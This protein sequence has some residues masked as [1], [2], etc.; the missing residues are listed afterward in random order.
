MRTD[1]LTSIPLFRDLP[2]DEFKRLAATLKVLTLEP[3]TILFRQGDIGESFYIIITGQLEVVLGI[4]TTNERILSE[5]GPGE[6]LG[7]VGL[8]IPDGHRSASVRAKTHAQLW[9]M[10]RHDF[11]SLLHR[12]PKLAYAMVEVLGTRLS[13]SNNAAFQELLEKNRELQVAYN[14]LKTAQAQIIEKERLEK[15]LQLAADIQMSILPFKVPV[16]PGVDF[17]AR[18]LPA[19]TVGG[20]LYDIFR[21]DERHVGVLIGDVADKGIPSA[22]F[23]A[24]THALITAEALRTQDPAVVLHQVNRYLTHLEQ[25]DLFVTVIYGVYDVWTGRFKYARAGHEVPL[26]YKPDTG[27]SILPRGAGQPIGM[28]DAIMIDEKELEIPVGGMLLL[29]TDGIT[30]CRNPAGEALGRERLEAEFKQFA[31]HASQTACDEL[32]QVLQDF[33]KGMPQ[34]DDVTLVTIRRMG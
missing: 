16:V 2:P 32:I 27:L 15:E 34:D 28:F 6:F 21:I 4:D 3:G 5:C 17:G 13:S 25:S 26:L 18:I 1:L 14:E 23:M 22:I 31:E 8:I 30:D 19:R 9:E 11:D 10:T 24:R 29:Y 33:Q 7:E 12:H 20:D